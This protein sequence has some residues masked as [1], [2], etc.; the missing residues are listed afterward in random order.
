MQITYLT[1]LSRTLVWALTCFVVVGCGGGDGGG[2]GTTTEEAGLLPDQS[3]TGISYDKTESGLGDSVQEAIDNLFVLF[4]GE[5]CPTDTKQVG[6]TC[7]ENKR[8]RTQ[9]NPEGG[10]NNAVTYKVASE[11]C[12]AKNRTLCSYDVLMNACYAN[13]IVDFTLGVVGAAA[14]WTT[15]IVFISGGGYVES[16][17]NIAVF[18][19]LNSGM[20]EVTCRSKKSVLTY[21]E[22]MGDGA[23]YL[24]EFRCCQPAN[25]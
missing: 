21:D 8:D 10:D 13:A 11:T 15:S 24:S 23:T 3:A 2:D 9:V 22:N 14:E 17:R 5:V 7:V 20:D 12:R 4:Q 18:G 16:F 19:H 25:L 1:Y 6:P